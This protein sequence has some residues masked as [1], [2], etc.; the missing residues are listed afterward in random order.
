[1]IPIAQ[2]GQM[3]TVTATDFSYHHKNPG[4]SRHGSYK[5]TAASVLDDLTY[6]KRHYFHREKQQ[7]FLKARLLFVVCLSYA[8]SAIS[9]TIV[10]QTVSFNFTASI[11]WSKTI[12]NWIL[13]KTV[14]VFITICHRQLTMLE[15]HKDRDIICPTRYYILVLYPRGSK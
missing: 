5:C 8:M 15:M 7:Y 4:C 12:A 14:T 6:F 13:L 10:L 2:K 1:M 9:K 3:L 11:W